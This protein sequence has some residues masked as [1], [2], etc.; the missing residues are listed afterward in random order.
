MAA[1]GAG[2]GA[3]RRGPVRIGAH[4]SVA[5]GLWRAFARAEA[6]GAACL[7]VFL[8]SAR[9]WAARPLAEEEVAAFRAEARRTGLPVI[10]H[11]SYLVNLATEQPELRERSLGCVRD[12]LLRCERLGVSELVLHPGSHPDP[13]RGLALIAQGLDALHAATPDVQS[14]LCLEVTAGQGNTLGWRLEH[15]ED[16]LQRVRQPDRLSVCLDTCH[17]HAAGYD[18]STGKG[19]ASVLDEADRRFGLQRVTCLHLNDCRGP[20]GCRVDRHEDVGQGTLGLDA[21]RVLLR[22]ARLSGAVGV[23]ETPHPERY[24]EGIRLLASLAGD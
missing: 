8:R 16:I 6:D 10:A 1:P 7:Q 12:E 2:V 5:G 4:T 15:L 13:A 24:G 21:F 20:R 9:S 19:C 22:D 11:G 3:A 18:L 14:R 23:L 17:L